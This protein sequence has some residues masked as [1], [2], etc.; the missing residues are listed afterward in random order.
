M[1]T[2]LLQVDI[3]SLGIAAIEMAESEPPY[4]DYPPLRALFLIATH[5][6]PSLKEPERTTCINFFVIIFGVGGVLADGGCEKAFL[7]FG[8][9]C[10]CADDWC[11][12]PSHLM[13]PPFIS[14]TQPNQR[15]R[16]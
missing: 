15:E 12:L 1:P 10:G 6:S 4:L 2:S 7:S 13:F 5:G 16:R 11:P 9:V 8:V 3:W 14:T